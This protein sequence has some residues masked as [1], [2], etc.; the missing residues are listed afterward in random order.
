MSDPRPLADLLAA[1][2]PDEVDAGCAAGFESVPGG[3]SCF[4]ILLPASQSLWEGLQP[5]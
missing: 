2:G 1:D 5:H 4:R 3:G